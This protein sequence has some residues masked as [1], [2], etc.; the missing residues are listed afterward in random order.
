MS[1]QLGSLGSPQCAVLGPGKESAYPTQISLAHV[2]SRT[3]G[4]L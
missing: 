4:A 1:G 2:G 3:S